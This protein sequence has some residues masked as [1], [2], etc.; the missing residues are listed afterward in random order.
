MRLPSPVGRIR[1][2]TDET[3]PEGWEAVQTILTRWMNGGCAQVLGRDGV[4]YDLTRLASVSP[5]ELAGC[6][7]LIFHGHVL[8]KFPPAV[9]RLT[10]DRRPE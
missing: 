3:V 9:H 10:T 8:M 7:L 5:Q 2:G 6:E 1:F 4:V